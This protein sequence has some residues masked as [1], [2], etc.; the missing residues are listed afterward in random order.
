MGIAGADDLLSGNEGGLL[1]A[2]GSFLFPT[3]VDRHLGGLKYYGLETSA[4][5]LAGTTDDKPDGRL[6]YF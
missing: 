1:R 6:Q 4:L 3:H 2:A 5:Q